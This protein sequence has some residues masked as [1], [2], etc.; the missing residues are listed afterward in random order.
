MD[1]WILMTILLCRQFTQVLT[2]FGANESRSTNA[3]S[4]LRGGY[5]VSETRGWTRKNCTATTKASQANGRIDKHLIVGTIH[6]SAITSK[7]LVSSS[8]N[9]LPALV[10]LT[11]RDFSKH[12]TFGG[13]GNTYPTANSV[14][15]TATRLKKYEIYNPLTYQSSVYL[16]IYIYICICIYIYII[17][18]QYVTYIS[19]SIPSFVAYKLNVGFYGFVWKYRHSYNNQ[20]EIGGCFVIRRP[21]HPFISNYH[22]V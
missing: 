12:G 8:D 6:G 7:L 22:L 9:T 17:Y 10:S 16:Y 20:H 3:P 4:R 18:I 21:L 14:P 5:E 19:I 1:W 13:R 15:Y 2:E 11:H